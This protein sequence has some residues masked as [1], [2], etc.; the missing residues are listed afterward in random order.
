[1]FVDACV[2]LCY[3][4][5]ITICG[6]F[7]VLYVSLP[8]NTN[9]MF[10]GAYYEGIIETDFFFFAKIYDCPFCDQANVLFMKSLRNIKVS[11]KITKNDNK[12][13]AYFECFEFA[14][15]SDVALHFWNVWV[16]PLF[17]CLPK[18]LTSSITIAIFLFLWQFL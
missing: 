14:F 6:L 16:A 15:C 18:V 12:C 8:G 17:L 9:L 3:C 11:G 4:G 1:M 5:D 10:Q 13:D 7:C 2:Y